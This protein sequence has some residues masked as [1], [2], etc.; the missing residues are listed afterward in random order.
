MDMSGTV[1]S[2]PVVLV[3]DD[4]P[5]IRRLVAAHM[6]QHGFHVE[7]AATGEEALEKAPL[8]QPAAVVLDISMPGMGGFEALSRLREWYTDPVIILSATD[9]EREKVRA[10][11]LGA[12]DYVTKP[13]GTEELAARLR[14]AIRRA[15]RLSAADSHSDPTVDAHDFQ[16][17]LASRL[18]YRE[19]TEVKLTRTEFELLRTMAVDAGKVLTHRHLLQTVWGPEYGAET[20]YLRTFV[21][22]LRRKLEHDPSRPTRILTEPGVGYRLFL[23]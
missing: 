6:S 22:Q 3:V 11:D 19:G 2:L 20:E 17:D 12:D 10:L 7:L 5:K 8:H 18:V 15:E 4:D 13:F 16:I 1:E 14:A 23:E 21:K 9:Q